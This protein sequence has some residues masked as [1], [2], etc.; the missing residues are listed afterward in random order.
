[1]APSVPLFLA[2]SSG[3]R[4]I[5]KFTL[6]AWDPIVT[7]RQLGAYIMGP[8]VEMLRVE[9]SA[10]ID[11][12]EAAIWTG[13]F[14]DYTVD[15]AA[16]VAKL[17]YIK[18]VF[19]LDDVLP[20]PAAVSNPF[21]RMMAD[22]GRRPQLYWP[23]LYPANSNKEA[24]RTLANEIIMADSRDKH[25]HGGFASAESAATAKTSFWKLAEVLYAAVPHAGPLESR[26]MPIPKDF[27]DLAE[28]QWIDSADKPSCVADK[29]TINNN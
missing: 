25:I 12:V 5:Q 6:G 19:A 1:M 21:T 20:P 24:F 15:F 4:T 17:I 11:G 3:P 27:R 10:T 18:C 9:A 16:N 28:A 7:I 14:L 29:C 2:A 8:T 22:P 13:T 23:Q 26:S